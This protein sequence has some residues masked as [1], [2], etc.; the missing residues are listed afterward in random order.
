MPTRLQAPKARQRGTGAQA[1]ILMLLSP[2]ALGG[3]ACYPT[4]P[5]SVSTCRNTQAAPG[6]TSQ[7]DCSCW[8]CSWAGR[9]RP[10]PLSLPFPAH[11]ASRSQLQVA[12]R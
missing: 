10:E 1:A 7:Q 9:S 4:Q 12:K 3:W 5:E 11:A 8:L 6:I 2:H